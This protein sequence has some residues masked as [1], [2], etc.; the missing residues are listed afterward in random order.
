M[1]LIHAMQCSIGKGFGN[2]ICAF[3]FMFSRKFPRL[4]DVQPKMAADPH[5]NPLPAWISLPPMFACVVAVLATWGTGSLLLGL[6][7]AL[8]GAV[9]AGWWCER[10]LRAVVTPI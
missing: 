10:A 3:S 7:T 9:A 1:P 6:A 2:R 5:K 4:R 8:V